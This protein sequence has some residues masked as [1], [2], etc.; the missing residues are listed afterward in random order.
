MLSDPVR[1]GWVDVGGLRLH[2]LVWQSHLVRHNETGAGR[3]L[4]CLHGVTG[5][6]WVWAAF[7]SE[8]SDRPVIALDLRGHGDSS[9]APD[10]DYATS[11]HAA[12]TLAVLDR[13]GLG[14]VDLVG[15][16]WG[17]LIAAALAA[18]YPAQ[19]ARLVMIDVP[20]SFDQP[21]DSPPPRPADFASAAGVVAYER[22]AN[23]HADPATLEL[24]AFG[25]VRP[26]PAGRLVRKHDEVFLKRWPFR[27]EDH[28]SLLPRLALPT[29]VVRATDSPVLSEEVADRMVAS[30]GQAERVDIGPSGHLVPIDAPRALA[31]VIARFTAT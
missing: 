24:F 7:A 10:G 29:L 6:A 28:W 30:M 27:D 16:S 21:A 3:P 5:Q 18:A 31:A 2:H 1:H 4:V 25:G 14:P 23:Q 22:S 9:W 17:G 8:L 15:L 11:T 12:D 19:V 20:P 13:L 26:G